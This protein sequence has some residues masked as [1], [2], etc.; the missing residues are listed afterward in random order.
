MQSVYLI[1]DLHSTY[2]PHLK[3]RKKLEAKYFC[4]D[5]RS[6]PYKF[7]GHHTK[8]TRTV[9]SSGVCGDGQSRISLRLKQDAIVGQEELSIKTHTL[10]RLI[11]KGI[12][13]ILRNTMASFQRMINAAW[14]RPTTIGSLRSF[15]NLSVISLNCV[16]QKQLLKS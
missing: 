14:M 3:I 16:S 7:H 8:N 1:C 6:V 2:A 9:T 4:F 5:H 12:W 13:R 11:S 15:P 10:T